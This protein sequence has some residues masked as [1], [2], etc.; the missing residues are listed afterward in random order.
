MPPK[1]Q[2]RAQPGSVP[3]PPAARFAVAAGMGLLLLGPA[4]S[5]WFWGVNGF[6]G[7]PWA[8]RLLLLAVAASCAALPRLR[9][10]STATAAALG[11]VLAAVVAFAR[12]ERL[13][14]LSDANVRIGAMASS[15]VMPD[16]AS[17]FE[18][19]RRIHAQ[20]LDVVVN[21][22]VPQVF[23]RLGMPFEI[24]LSCVS[25]GLA[26]VFFAGVWR[27]VGRLGHAQGTR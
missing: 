1:P 6:R 19:A 24:A 27:L 23:V 26:L 8:E 18:W 9:T 13:H 20:P 14:F 7:L 22:I 5:N 3:P 16:Q 4:A 2:K 11:V 10:R 17:I 15:A 12:R 21:I 25:F